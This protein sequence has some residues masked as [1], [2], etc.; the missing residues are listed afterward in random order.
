MALYKRGSK[1]AAVTKLKKQLYDLEYLAVAPTHDRFGGDTEKAVKAF[2]TAH[3]LEADGI[4]GP[5]TIAA[6]DACAMGA[7][8]RHWHDD[9]IKAE[10]IKKREQMLDIIEKRVGDLYVW[11]AQ[12]HLPAES[13]IRERMRNKPL[14]VSA[15]RGA[16][17]L[18]YA[19]DHPNKYNGEPLRCEDCSGLFW[20]AENI[21]ELP[22]DKSGRDVD[23]STAAGLY[24]AYCTPISKNELQPL[25]LV[26][27]GWPITHVGIVGRNG[28]IYEAAGSEIGVVCS[29]NVDVRRFRS[30]YGPAY[31]C[32]EYYSKV[33]WTRFGR[34]KIFAEYG[35]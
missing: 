32:K 23:D 11:G 10:L 28:K 7:C 14:Q 22:L 6:L 27:S 17:M 18:R 26:F 16:R 4:V 20:A 19:A 29:D 30:I 13:Y 9:D 5:L 24:R 12:G 21:V 31:G 1:G 35:I 34:L 15:A 2:Q 33:K 8:N 3:A 25:D